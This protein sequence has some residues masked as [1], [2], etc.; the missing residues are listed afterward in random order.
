MAAN[1]DLKGA[2]D[3]VRVLDLTRL[4]PGPF[5][6]LLL[7]DLGADVIKVEHPDGGDYARHYPPKA[8]SD[9][10]FGAFFGSINRNKRSVA[11]D[12]KA[13]AGAETFRELAAEADVVLESFRPGVME[14]L[15]LGWETL[16]AINDQL[17]Y[18]AISGYGQDGPLAD[19][20]GHDLNYLARAGI[21]RHN[22]APDGQPVVPG[23]QL[24]DIAGGGLYAAFSTVTAL[25]ARERGAGGAF[26]DISM[27]EGALSFHLPTHAAVSVGEDSAPNTGML[28]GGIP[29][30]NVYETADGRYLAV[31]PLE[32]KFWTEFLKVIEAPELLAEGHQRGV[33]GRE[34]R[35]ALAEIIAGEDLATWEERLEGH[36]VCC[37]GVRTLEEVVKDELF[38]A[39][40]TFFELAGVRHVRTPVTPSKFDHRPAPGLGADT[41]E[42]LAEAGFE[43]ERIESLIDQGVVRGSRK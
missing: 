41:S 20:A 16:S 9:D 18:C 27:T 21:L 31:G 24:A 42:V 36:E 8:D 14:R 25:F 32:P 43:R 26:L 19:R 35:E 13:E 4:L 1:D 28:D 29:A 30:Y 11:I 22:A 33:E 15:G 7:A 38:E 5:A 39:R 3:G 37:E 2:L 6:S 40:E 10:E 34:A 12:L 23:F 17:V